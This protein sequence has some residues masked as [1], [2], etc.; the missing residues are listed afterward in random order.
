MHSFLELGFLGLKVCSPS[1][2]IDRREG[3]QCSFS[4]PIGKQEDVLG[5]KP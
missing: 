1:A 4:L 5:T 2:D 3:E